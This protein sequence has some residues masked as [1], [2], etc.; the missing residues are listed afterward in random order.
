MR[1]PILRRFRTESRGVAI[2]E[3]AMLAPLMILLYVGMA[4]LVQGL[5]AERKSSHAASAIGDLVAQSEEVTVGELN[6]IFQIAQV[7]I[8][9]FPTNGIQ[10]RVSSVRVDEQD[11]PRVRWSQANGYWTPRGV[12]STVDIPEVAQGDGSSR[13]FLARGQ[14]TVMAEVVYTF[15]S[16]FTEMFANV[17]AWFGSAPG[18]HSDGFTFNSVYYLQPRQTDEVRLRP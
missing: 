5:M 8:E 1:S 14:S 13:D 12:N 16:P 10:L 18:A 9:P 7:I 4:E 17:Q 3:F 2:V 15:E 6:Q 11:V